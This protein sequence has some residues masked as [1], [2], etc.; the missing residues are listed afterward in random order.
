VLNLPIDSKLRKYDVVKMR[1]GDIV[2]G[3]Y[4]RTRRSSCRRKLAGRC[5]SSDGLLEWQSQV[6]SDAVIIMFLQ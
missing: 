4:V 6:S 2:L 5:S 1:I 3:G